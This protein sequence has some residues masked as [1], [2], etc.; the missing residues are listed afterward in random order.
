MLNWPF[1][2]IFNKSEPIL[3]FPPLF[4]YFMLGWPVSILIVYLF[5]RNMHEESPEDESGEGKP[6]S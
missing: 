2:Q 5:S 3:D 6:G 4:L 1:I